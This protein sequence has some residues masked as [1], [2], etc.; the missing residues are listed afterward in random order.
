MTKACPLE[1]KGEN[2]I[3]LTDT[4]IRSAD[5]TKLPEFQLPVISVGITDPLN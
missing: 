5:S 2:G 4:G 3:F 1:S